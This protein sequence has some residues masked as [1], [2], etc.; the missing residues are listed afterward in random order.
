MRTWPTRLLFTTLVWLASVTSAPAAPIPHSPYFRAFVGYATQALGDVNDDVQAWSSYLSPRSTSLDWEEIG[1]AA[2][3]GGEIGYHVSPLVSVGFGVGYQK[4]SQ[5]HTATIDFTD[6]GGTSY[7]GSF[8][9]EPEVS[10]LDFYGAVTLWVPATPGLHFGGQIGAA[11]GKYELSQATD[12][13]AS[14]GSFEVSTFTG[15]AD[16]TVLSAGLYAGYEVPVAPM[17]AVSG[18]AGYRFCDFGHMNGDFTFAG[19]DDVGPFFETGSGQVTNFD[20]NPMSID[21][22][23]LQLHV[24]LI[25]KFPSY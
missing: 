21:L 12:I 16:K 14:D 18:R 19:T 7:F 3:F 22:S 13:T 10:V 4:G 9:E 2:N 23:G 1:G 5:D 6:I 8:A 20:G 15:E 25:L 24:G 11:R 17:V